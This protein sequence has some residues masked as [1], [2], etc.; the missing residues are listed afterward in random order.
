MRNIVSTTSKILL[1]A[2][3]L[4]LAIN[5]SKEDNDPVVGSQT[6]SATEVRTILDLD[7]QSSVVDKV[8]TEIFQNTPSGKSAKQN[9]C[10]TTEFTNTGY[11]VTFDNCSFE[12]SESVNG[13]IVVTY[14][15]GEESTSFTATYSD[16]MVG[17]IKINGT[18]AF[19][20][21]SENAGNNMSFSIVTNMVVTLEDNSVI[22]E[23]GTKN[24]TF[25]IDINNLQNSGLTISGNW[26]VK[27]DGNTYV[28]STN[29]PLKINLFGCDYVG[30]GILSI[31]KNGLVVTV[32]FGDGTCDS[33]ATVKYPDGTEEEISLKKD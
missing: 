19:T 10:Y 30:E 29:E 2:C 17:A 23:T 21:N 26:T 15:E 22:E 20:M 32:D 14:T 4:V 8:I 16:L 33:L 3:L 27:A 6:V 31:S 13:T 24:F 18:R 12:G 9:D 1:L 5:C 7:D 28:V 25:E 11:T